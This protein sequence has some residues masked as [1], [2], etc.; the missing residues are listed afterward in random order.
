VSDLDAPLRLTEFLRLRRADLLARWQPTDPIAPLLDRIA[1]R[2]ASPDAPHRTMLEA[3]DDSFDLPGAIDQLGRLRDCVLELWHPA[4]PD[5]VRGFN[6]AVDAAIHELV[7]RFTAKHARLYAEAQ[8]AVRVREDVLAIVS[9]DLRNPLGTID[10][11]ASLLM[12]RAGNDGRMRKQ[13]EIIRRSATRMA[14]L[15]DD[16]L[17]MAS[18]GAGR[19]SLASER[20]DAGDIITEVSE[21]HMQQ[22]AEAHVELVVDN[23]LDGVELACDRARL[24]QV[25][26]NLLGNAIKFCRAGDRITLTATGDD[27]QARFEVRDTG[28][29]IA[30]SEIPRIFDP[31]W[32]AQRHATKGTGLG[33]YIC[34]GIIE[35]HGGTLTVESNLG[36]G[37]TFVVSLP[38][39]GLASA[40]VVG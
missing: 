6:R 3:V 35:A 14:H 40:R 19:L 5:D 39:C 31:Y 11:S 1:E 37:A 36:A 23:Q 16:L 33:L 34:K 32:S 20:V 22:A 27:T 38:A 2:A 26:G 7:D 8:H 24:I 17:D 9:H 28:P 4:R 21:T 12:Q 10:L 18:I 30:A 15:I 13:L 29:G 25:F